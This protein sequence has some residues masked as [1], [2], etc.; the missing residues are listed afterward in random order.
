MLL[1]WCSISET[2]QSDNCCCILSA[3]MEGS[4]DNTGHCLELILTDLSLN[5]DS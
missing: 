5:Y 1:K 4:R 3:L 2:H